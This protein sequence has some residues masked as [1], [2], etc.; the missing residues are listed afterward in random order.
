MLIDY[1]ISWVSRGRGR[2]GRGSAHSGR[3]GR[4]EAS[5]GAG[6][7]DNS[8]LFAGASRVD[9]TSVEAV[10]GVAEHNTNPT[11]PGFTTEQVQR[12]M[13]LLEAPTSGTEKLSGNPKPPWLIESGAS[14]HMT[15][16]VSSLF[17]IEKVD[18][19]IIDIPN[20]Q[21]TIADKQGTIVLDKNL[22]LDK[23]LLV[24]SL[25]YNL[26]SVSR[27]CKDLHCIVTFS[28]DSCIFQDRNTKIPIGLSE[29]V[30]GVYMY[31]PAAKKSDSCGKGGAYGLAPS[32]RSPIF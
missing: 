6:R 9:N 4:G 17:N 23:T 12:L 21:R 7:T 15:G 8:G 18:P 22:S 28:D 2:G 10:S 29:Q 25:T 31:K 16:E 30:D 32:A 27:V 5:R 3:G 26:V 14:T 13:S 20:G 1:P 11:L 19:V 24:P